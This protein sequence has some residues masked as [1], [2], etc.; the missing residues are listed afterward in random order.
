MRG[1]VACT[2]L[3]AGLLAG[4]G[5]GNGPVA[6]DSPSVSAAQRATCR[7]LLDDLPTEL[8]GQPSRP[9][10]P[11]DALGAAWGDPAITLTC[12]VGV[13]EDYDQ[14]AYCQQTDGVGWYIPDAA[15]Q[16]DSSDVTFTT[17]GYRP[18]IQVHLP[19]SYRPDTGFLVELAPVVKEHLERVSRCQ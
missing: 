4:C 1:A 3:L 5:G 16:D 9:V 6:I 11:S 15:L 19:S 8:A 7:A 10:T 12:G 14:F 2:A 17:V 13:P 18:R